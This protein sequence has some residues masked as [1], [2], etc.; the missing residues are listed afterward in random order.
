MAPATTA[1]ATAVNAV[2]AAIITEHLRGHCAGLEAPDLRAEG[3]ADVQRLVR[4]DHKIVAQVL[5][6]WE[7]PAK[8]CGARFQIKA[9]QRAA[10]RGAGW[11]RIDLAGPQRTG[12]RIGQHAEK[13]TTP[14]AADVDKNFSLVGPLLG[15]VDFW[16]RRAAE[17]E[18]A[19]RR[20]C[21][22]LGL[23]FFR[24]RHGSG[25]GGRCDQR[26]EAGSTDGFACHESVPFG[27]ILHG[28]LPCFVE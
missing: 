17:D 1:L 21:N 7:F 26:A 4:P 3:V 28:S 15:A 23:R 20:N 5:I 6:A 9:T 19:V 27:A 13:G 22:A 24:H 12:R 11:T 10:G 25:L 18:I 2:Q 16:A 14:I 8:F